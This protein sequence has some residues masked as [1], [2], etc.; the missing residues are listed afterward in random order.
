[1]SQAFIKKEGIAQSYISRYLLLLE[2]GHQNI[3]VNAR[4]T[5]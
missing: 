5:H 4:M 2:N 1:M 3:T